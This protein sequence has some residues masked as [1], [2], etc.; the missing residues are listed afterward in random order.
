VFFDSLFQIFGK[1][2]VKTFIFFAL[3]NVDVVHE[4]LLSQESCFA[5]CYAEATQFKKATQD[6]ASQQ[7]TP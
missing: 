2:S 6:T 4:Y 3:E 7:K 5:N 1:T